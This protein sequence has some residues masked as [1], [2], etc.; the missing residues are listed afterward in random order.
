MPYLI[1]TSAAHM[2]GS[3]KYGPYYRLAVLEVTEGTQKVAM[4]SPRAR[5]VVRV[6]ATWEKL[7]GGAKTE[8]GAYEL[9]KKEA[10]EMVASL[11]KREARNKRRREAR[12]LVRVYETFFAGRGTLDGV[13]S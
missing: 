12:A 2:P 13:E 3:C 8:R 10:Q 7:W 6:I 11:E 9:A 5:G 1:K 4:I